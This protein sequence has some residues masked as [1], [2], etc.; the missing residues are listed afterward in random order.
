MKR[1]QTD[2]SPLNDESEH[3]K[4]SEAIRIHSIRFKITAITIAAILTTILSILAAC[5]VT[6]Q[7]ENDRRSVEIMN[8]ISEETKASLE[9]Y[10]Q[11]IVQSVEMTANIATDTL[12]RVTLVVN[13]GGGQDANPGDRTPEQTKQ[14]DDYISR[15]CA[16]IQQAFQSVASRTQGVVSYYYVINPEISKNVHGFYYSR[17]GKT[18][19]YKQPPI[20]ARTLDRADTEHDHWYFIPVNRG[21]PC[22][23]EPFL[24]KYHNEQWI[25][26]YLVPV[27]RAGA[28]IGLLGMDIP[29]ETLVDR[30]SHI[31]VYET[32]FASLYDSLNRVIYHPHLPLGTTPY[33]A[34]LTL[35]RDIFKTENSGDRLIRY[36]M[37]GEERQM[38]FSTLSTGMKLV[39]SAPV[40]EII[41]AWTRLTR[42]ITIITAGVIA[43]FVALVLVVMSVITRPLKKLTDASQRLANADYNVALTYRGKDEI[44]MLTSA[45]SQMRDQLKRYIEDLNR[46]IHTDNMTGLPNMRRFF[47][48]AL[49]SRDR[50]LAQGGRPAL[51]YF[52]LVGMKNFNRQFGF[53]DGDQLIREFANILAR[54]YGL[55][56]VGRLSDDHF[57]AVADEDRAEATLA[58]IFL[59]CRV[60]NGGRQV[61]V[62]VGIYPDRLESVNVNVACDRAKYACDQ[63]RD[64]Y[65]SGFFYFDTEM[66]EHAENI[67]YIIS[68]LDQALEQRWIQVW[69]QPIIRAV[70]GKVCDEEALSRWLDPQ[71]GMLSPGEFIPILE[72]A[73]L[74]YKVDL[75]VLERVLEKMQQ[76]RELGLTVVPHSINL[77]R[78][79]FDTC[80]IVEEIR[81]RVDSAGIRRDMITIEITESI[82]GGDFEF[83][84][85]QIER[86]QA[87]GFPV[88]MDDFGS[89][90]SSLEVLQSVRFDLLKFDMSF[91]RRLDQ[92]ENVKIILTEMMRMATSLGVDTVCEGVETPEH[93]QFLREIG[94]SKLQGYYFCK[95]ISLDRLLERYRTGKQIGFENPAEAGYYEA[96]GRVN[97]YD[98]A[99]MTN[100]DDD[101]L[102][103]TFDTLPMGIVEMQGEQTRFIR[104][105]PSFRAFAKRF[106]DCDL[107]DHGT[108]AHAGGCTF[109]RTLR[110]SIAEE[111][112]AFFD[113]VLPDGSTARAF[114]RH[115]GTNPVTG[116]TAAAVAVLS[117]AEPSE[118]T[119]YASIARALA[120][121]YYNL[122]YVDLRTDS[123]IEY[124]SNVGDEELAVE[125]HGENFFQASRA[126][127]MARIYSEDR[128]WMLRTFTKENILREL[129]RQGVF[130]ATYRL[131]DSGAPVY[132]SMKIMRMQSDDSH[133]IIGVSIVDSQMK[134]KAYLDEL[135]R[136]RDT[137][138][139]VM[140]LSDNYLTLYS[141]NPENDRYIEYNATDEYRTLGLAQEGED[142]FNAS[143]RDS[144]KAIAPED[145]PAF[146]ERFSKEN[147]LRE[148]RENGAFHLQYHLIIRGKLTPVHLK[149]VSIR[150]SAGE[151]LVVGVHLGK[152]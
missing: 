123:F 65:A 119:S 110:A 150:E 64:E 21:Q 31:K 7:T 111:N 11:S 101:P 112:R 70:D 83:M 72:N 92:S 36:S 100:L 46:R 30:I 68:H 90:Y 37:N 116:A 34:G 99:M 129:D 23:I 144:Q 81:C 62:R 130:T 5:N 67:R 89:G 32:G 24:D 8:L 135:A 57:A 149:I 58:E 54:H 48:L 41:A 124:T 139:R 146:M 93:V 22:W 6:I 86:F 76:F 128:E 33:E 96:I 61:P 142:F 44:G 77:S 147:I 3:S 60:A 28:Y 115:I 102:R 56:N 1:I 43:F 94:C 39:V 26:S 25:I 35:T 151:R 134:Q 74:I 14:L 69:Y 9:E 18:G 152:D 55:E 2:I 136:E 10:L 87:L 105:N 20:D 51:L 114:A 131:M 80:D 143:I 19:F 91:V 95:P 109:I 66:L 141:V 98:L 78:S 16:Q 103:S 108:C 40:S 71:K 13:R 132:A 15:H 73:R 113:D 120:A 38:T 106:F 121:D 27:Y 84:R 52:N 117:V 82:I 50:I 29:V 137:L 125:R 53:D 4:E 12:D 75:Y 107:T 63:H 79:D 45:F 104:S 138:A 85:G 59:E 118:G 133:I 17:M 49:S 148:I 145:L 127:T 122:Y 140:A 42:I 97:L 47:K 88:W 126:E